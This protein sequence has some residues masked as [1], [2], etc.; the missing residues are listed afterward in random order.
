MGFNGRYNEHGI[1]V[2]NNY[3]SNEDRFRDI[4]REIDSKYTGM[5]VADLEWWLAELQVDLDDLEANPWKYSFL[6]E[7]EAQ[8][9]TQLKDK[10]VSYV[11]Y[12]KK[13]AEKAR[14][15]GRNAMDAVAGVNYEGVDLADT[16]NVENADDVGLMESAAEQRKRSKDLLSG[17]VDN[18]TTDNHQGYWDGPNAYA[19]KG[20]EKVEGMISNRLGQDSKWDSK[21][22]QDRLKSLNR[23]PNLG[24][25]KP[26]PQAPLGMPGGMGESGLSGLTGN[27]ISKKA[28]KYRAAF[29]NSGSPW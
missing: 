21:L 8:A 4:M 15:T 20:K 29:S 2:W 10:L 17:L 11:D 28:N 9:M 7:S 25:T 6:P 14:E 13:G 19:L 23:F 22:E 27:Y 26:Q 12:H 1:V 5:S 3:A 24:F 16:G 18:V